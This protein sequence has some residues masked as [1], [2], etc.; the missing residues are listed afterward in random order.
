MKL[1]SK[2]EVELRSTE[3][4]DH[5]NKKTAIIYLNNHRMDISNLLSPHGT[6]PILLI[7]S[8]V[9]TLSP[10]SFVPSFPPSCDALSFI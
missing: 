4:V 7:C 1:L 5:G 9:H 10:E 8:H 2:V 3:C 6:I